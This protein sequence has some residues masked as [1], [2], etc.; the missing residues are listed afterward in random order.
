MT[1]MLISATSLDFRTLASWIGLLQSV[2]LAVGPIVSLMCRSLYDC[3]KSAQYWSS[4]IKLSDLA[5]FQLNWWFENL[6]DLNGF[7]ICK[8]PSIVKFEFSVAGDASDRGFFVYRVDSKQRLFSRPFSVAESQQSSTFKELTA[9]HET[10]TNMDI[11]KEFSNNTVGH[12]TDNKAVT[13]ILSGGSRNPGLQKLSLEI[14]LSLRKFRILLVPIW[15]SRENEIISW[16]DWGSRDFRSDDYSLDPVTLTALF[17]KF[18]KFT[19]DCMANSANAVCSKF[20]SRYSSPGSSGVNFFAQT[21][22]QKDHYYC[23][24][25]VR[26]AVDAI[27]HLEKFR[28]SGILVIPIWPRSQ[29]F[30]WF[31]P[32]GVHASSWV[33]SLELINPSYISSQ[34]VGCCFKGFQTF[35]TAVL[36]FNFQNNFV[37]FEPK[38]HPAFCLKKGCILC[39]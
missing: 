21:L 12:Y 25:P 18:G 6:Q 5:R 38:I 31:F 22:Y 27:L 2:R 29:I 33:I 23:F 1:R 8:E 10:W 17:Q 14:F 37:S 13:F 26:K 7:P 20:Y 19:V 3:I 11:L 39:M 34:S 15:V 16:A 9:V 30:L 24:P 4:Y 28:V 36:K 32:D 35:D